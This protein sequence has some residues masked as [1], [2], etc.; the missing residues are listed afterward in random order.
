LLRRPKGQETSALRDNI[1]A[2]V[3]KLIAWPAAVP[4]A[5]SAAFLQQF[6]TAQRANLERE[7]LFGRPR[8]E[9]KKLFSED[10]NQKTFM[11]LARLSA[12]QAA[13]HRV[14]RTRFSKLAGIV[15]VSPPCRDV[16]KFGGAQSVRRAAAMA[17]LNVKSFLGYHAVAFGRSELALSRAKSPVGGSRSII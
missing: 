13:R 14:C 6:Y 2:R 17:S 3:C 9:K 10:N 8:D 16:D 11:S 7:K 4:S 12:F 5:Q 15:T 1:C